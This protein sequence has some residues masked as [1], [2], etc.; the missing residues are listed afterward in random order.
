MIWVYRV[1]TDD[2]LIV[3]YYSVIN[4]EQADYEQSTGD[5]RSSTRL[6][7]SSILLKNPCQEDNSACMNNRSDNYVQTVHDTTV[8]LSENMKQDVTATC[9]VVCGTGGPT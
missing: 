8:T 3:K 1:C 4:W 9:P 7:S 6:S 2:P 5:C